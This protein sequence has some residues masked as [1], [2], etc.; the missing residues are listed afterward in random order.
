MSVAAVFFASFVAVL[1]AVAAMALGVVFGRRAI[2]GSCGGIA[3][4]CAGCAGAASCPRRRSAVTP[5]D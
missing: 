4:R 5:D 3:G 2:S 1:G